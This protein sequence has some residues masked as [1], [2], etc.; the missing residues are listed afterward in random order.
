MPQNRWRPVSD[1]LH[2]LR[3]ELQDGQEITQAL[4]E[5]VLH[6][7]Q[8]VKERSNWATTSSK[9]GEPYDLVDTGQ[10]LDAIK[11]GA[12]TGKG[13]SWIA[14]VASIQELDSLRRPAFTLPDGTNIPAGKQ[15]YWRYL[16]WGLPPNPAYRFVPVGL[17]PYERKRRNLKV[18]KEGQSQSAYTSTRVE[19]HTKTAPGGRRGGKSY[20]VESHKKGDK[21]TTWEVGSMQGYKAKGPKVTNRGKEMMQA[22]F[23]VRGFMVKNTTGGPGHSGIAPTYLFRRGL[24]TSETFI[25]QRM[26]IAIQHVIAAAEKKTSK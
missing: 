8:Q 14:G 23:K 9:S 17:S 25:T 20:L 11:P 22:R 12:V 3:A 19:R 7:T 1:F 2:H 18:P 24:Q 26:T 15:S 16:E 4:N 13:S 5:I 10:F 21:R 6:I